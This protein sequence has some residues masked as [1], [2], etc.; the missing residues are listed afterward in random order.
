MDK[1]PVFA[2]C[3]LTRARPFALS[4]YGYRGEDKKFVVKKSTY[5]EGKPHLAKMLTTYAKLSEL[6]RQIPDVKV[7]SAEPTADGCVRF[8]FIEG[9]GAERVLI[10]LI[11]ENDIEGS[12]TLLRKLI[13]LIESLPSVRCNPCDNPEFTK[14]FGDSYDGDADCASYGLV[15]F[16]LDNVILDPKGGWHLID[17][18][19]AFEFPVPKQYLIQRFFYW[20]F[21]KRYQSILRYY[22]DRIP[23]N[24][25]APDITFPVY[26]YREFERYLDDLGRVV[27]AESYFQNYVAGRKMPLEDIDFFEPNGKKDRA[28]ARVG[29]LTEVQTDL[30]R[31]KTESEKLQAELD[32]IRLSNNQLQTELRNI[33]ASRA[34]RAAR[35]I[36]GAKSGITGKIRGSRKV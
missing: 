11:L 36:S 25:I 3:Q 24:L 7:A 21:I 32:D 33:H 34:Y 16:N 13:G 4:T 17:Y 22:A 10:D 1:Q 31:L 19:W 8:D 2:V 9:R 35:K 26:I 14:I 28:P 30:D 29:Y 6:E 20:F 12:L 5:D 15:D 18:E 27:K 23:Q